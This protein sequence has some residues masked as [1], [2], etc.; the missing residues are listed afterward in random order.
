MIA[1]LKCSPSVPGQYGGTPLHYAAGR[2]HLHIVKFL[3][4]EERCDPSH[5]ERD[6]TTPLSHAAAKGHLNVVKFLT[7]EKDCSPLM[8]TLLSIGQH[9]MAT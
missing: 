9:S 8:V 4:D 2:G 3:I 1:D 6:K 7:L 5:L